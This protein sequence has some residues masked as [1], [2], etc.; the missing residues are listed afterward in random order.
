MIDFICQG[1]V[2]GQT[3]GIHGMG[4]GRMPGFCQTKLYNPNT[5]RGASQPNVAK[6]ELG[7]PGSGMMTR[8]DV[9]DIVNYVRGM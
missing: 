9:A 1:S 4:T 3:Y 7:E 5:D 6:K 8:A 2:D